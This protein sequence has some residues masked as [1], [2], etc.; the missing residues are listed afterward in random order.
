MFDPVARAC[1]C[2]LQRAA[3]ENSARDLR[4][5]QAAATEPAVRGELLP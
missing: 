2:V 5:H 4:A 3:G 1:V